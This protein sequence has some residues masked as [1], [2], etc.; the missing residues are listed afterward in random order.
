MNRREPGLRVESYHHLRYVN[1]M[2]AVT[3]ICDEKDKYAGEV[4]V[5][6]YQSLLSAQK[7]S[8]LR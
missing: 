4:E 2:G 3:S 5:S 8:A 7:G 6:L 1:G